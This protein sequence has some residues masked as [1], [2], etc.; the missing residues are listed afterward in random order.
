[1]TTATAETRKRT[2]VVARI[3][4]RAPRQSDVAAEHPDDSTECGWKAIG[5]HDSSLEGHQAGLCWAG[6]QSGVQVVGKEVVEPNELTDPG[7]N[8]GSQY[9]ALG[10]AGRPS[11][12]RRLG[13]LTTEKSS[14]TVNP[15]ASE[16]LKP[17]MTI[18]FA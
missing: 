5:C 1:M 7:S 4:P 16:A 18:D 3:N 11:A 8:V 17:P 15:A 13:G 10:L 9:A 2:G 6:G 14:R 12:E